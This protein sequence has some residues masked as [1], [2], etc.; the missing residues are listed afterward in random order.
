MKSL[1]VS[2]L[3]FAAAFGLAAASPSSAEV[4]NVV[5]V[6]GAFAD[7]SGWRKVSD[8]LAARGYHVTVVQEPLT[9]LAD[10]VAA[11]RRVLALQ[12]GPTVLVG[13]SY[14]GMVI[15]DAGN[16][17]NVAGLVYVAAFEPEAGETLAGLA[18]TKPADGPAGAIQATGDGFLYLDPKLFG[19]AFAA[20]LPPAESDALARSQVFA[21]RA[22]FTAPAGDPAWKHKPSWALVA[23]DDRSINPQL[24]RDMARRAGSTMR[25][26]A[27]SH[28]VY[29]SHPDAVADLIVDAAKG[30]SK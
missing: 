7:G 12:D 9:G 23:R 28:A 10:D 3:A 5:I 1:S 6:H 11:T 2:L 4:R 25:E 24:E 8:I 15:S 19:A 18:G 22:A 13:H 27:S 26:I 21:A 20:D 17:P 14:A 30:A 29:A 16:A